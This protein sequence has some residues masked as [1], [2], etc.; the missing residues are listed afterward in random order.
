MDLGRVNAVRAVL[1]DALG[2]LIELEPPAPAL[3]GN[4]ARR[5]GLRLGRPAVERAVASEIAF[6]REHHQEGRNRAG[7]VGLRRRC[8]EVLRGG[9]GPAARDIPAH[10]LESALLAS[11]HFRPFVEVPDAL[12][13][14]RAAGLRLIVVSNWDCSLHDLLA[15][16][17]LAALVHGTITSAELGSAKPEPA[18]FRHALT[19]AGVPAA[20]AVHVGDSPVEDVDGARAAGIEP[21]L[22]VRDGVGPPVGS[23]A[24][25]PTVVRSLSELADAAT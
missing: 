25:P 10:E 13:L 21:I 15:R 2:T 18:I 24:P 3:E 8:T 6:Y 4:L 20:H 5:F 16:T 23:P 22:L 11:L 17:G 19:L 1:L 14:M 9:L 7:L 12:S